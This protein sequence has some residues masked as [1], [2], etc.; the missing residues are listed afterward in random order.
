MTSLKLESVAV[1]AENPLATQEEEGVK[2]VKQNGWIAP[3]IHGR[4]TEVVVDNLDHLQHHK[5]QIC[6]SVRIVVHSVLTLVDLS[7][8]HSPVK[9]GSSVSAFVGCSGIVAV[10]QL[11]YGLAY[12]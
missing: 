1:T 11:H 5:G 3:S 12:Y 6:F 7:G 10:E 9:W 8:T 2:V 4:A